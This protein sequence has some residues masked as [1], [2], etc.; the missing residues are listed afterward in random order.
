KDWWLQRIVNKDYIIAIAYNDNNVPEGYLIYEVK[1]NKCTIQDMAFQ[2]F[3]GRK[4]LFH[5]ISNHDSM[6]NEVIVDLPENDPIS[7]IIEE[8]RFQQHITPYFMARIVD[9]DSFLH[10]YSYNKFA[11]LPSFVMK[12]EDTFIQ[13]NTRTFLV[14]QKE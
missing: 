12:I 4:L 13:D 8:P 6:A 7:L 3:N 11:D 1:N 14:E 9:V 5:F 10:K 2:S